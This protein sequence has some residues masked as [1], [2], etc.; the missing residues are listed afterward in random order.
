MF[1]VLLTLFMAAT[2]PIGYQEAVNAVAALEEELR[3]KSD[4]SYLIS[5]RVDLPVFRNMQVWNQKSGQ[6]DALPA[7]GEAGIGARVRVVH[8]WAH[9][10]EPCQRE[11]PWLRVLVQ[12]AQSKYKGKVQYLFVAEDTTSEV[13]RGYQAKHK[14]LLPEGRLY[15]DTQGQLR[16]ALRPGLPGGEMKLPTTLLIDEKGVIRQAFV[17]PLSEPNDRRPEL[18]AAIERLL[19][20]PPQEAAGR[21]LP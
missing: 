17:G 21:P 7:N 16:D 18:L 5:Q 8:L 10:C 11:F 2:P 13:M 20:L 1:S 14:D 6:W 3:R 12:R 4:E 19:A 9:Y 15:H